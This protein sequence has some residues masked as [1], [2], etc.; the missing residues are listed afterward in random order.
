MVYSLGPL[1]TLERIRDLVS[2]DFDAVDRVIKQRLHSPVALV[3]QVA[4][5]RGDGRCFF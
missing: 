4:T 1:M 3:D 2:T 5:Y